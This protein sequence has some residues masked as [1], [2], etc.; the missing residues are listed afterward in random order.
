MR[1]YHDQVRAAARKA[2]LRRSARDAIREALTDPRCA[3]A[4]A[5]CKR[6][7]STTGHKLLDD[8]VAF[9]ALLAA[10]PDNLKAMME[11][12]ELSRYERICCL[13]DV[14]SCERPDN[15]DSTDGAKLS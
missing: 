4:I 5:E 1:S 8:N 3:R 9:E 14:L 13:N 11:R 15:T 12:G 6:S 7:G 2:Q 10:A